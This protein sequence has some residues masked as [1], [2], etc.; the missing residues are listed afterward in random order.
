MNQ[1]SC[2]F[3]KI[4]TEG[5]PPH[6]LLSNDGAFVLLDRKP[7]SFGHCMVVPRR[8]VAKLY[9]LEPTEHAAVLSLA[10]R[11]ATALSQALDSRSVAY[12][13]FGSG[14]PHAHLHL[15]P[16]DDP[17]VVLEP[18]KHVRTLSNEQLE[19][20]A[21]RLRNLLPA[22]WHSAGKQSAV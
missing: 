5:L 4:A 14:L 17:N 18:L 7:L 21:N 11:F 3:C 19:R 22:E 10:R 13:A 16:H 8:H 1:E 2:P 15:V 9:E 6:G 12:L 20:D